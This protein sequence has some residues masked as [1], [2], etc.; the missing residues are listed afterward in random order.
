MIAAEAE[1]G[2]IVMPGFNRRFSS[3][4]VAVR[5]F[6][7][8]RTSTIVIV[9]RVNACSIKADSWYKDNEEGGWQIVSEGCH[10]VDLIQFICG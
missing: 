6:F 10:F 4:S 2:K 9:C 3:L 5:D 1:T 7:A 8:G